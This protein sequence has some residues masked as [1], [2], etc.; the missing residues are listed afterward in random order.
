LRIYTSDE[1]PANIIDE[2]TRLGAEVVKMSNE[3]KMFGRF[4]IA[5]DPTVDRYIIR[6]ID[7]RLNT[8]ER[9]AVEEWIQSKMPL[10]SIRDHPNHC[11]TFNGGMWGGVRGAIP[12]LGEQ[13]RS[14]SKGSAIFYC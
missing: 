2:L 11:H 4:L 3:D 12:N 9:I 10:H 8:R 6:D 13:L 14:R 5:L 7:S 1:I